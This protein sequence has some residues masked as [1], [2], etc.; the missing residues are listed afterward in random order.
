MY[1]MSILKALHLG[2]EPKQGAVGCLRAPHL[3]DLCPGPCPSTF[4][5]DVSPTNII[6]YIRRFH[7]TDEY[8]VTFIDTDE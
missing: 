5:G 3:S 2:R 6:G 8:I 4:I 7:V 1:I